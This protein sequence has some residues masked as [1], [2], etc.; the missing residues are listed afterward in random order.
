MVSIICSAPRIGLS[1]EG[2]V[3]RLVRESWSKKFVVMFKDGRRIRYV[4]TLEPRF[5]CDLPRLLNLFAKKIPGFL[6]EI[7]INPSRGIHRMMKRTT[8]RDDEVAEKFKEIPGP[9]LS[10]FPVF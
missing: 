6:I 10:K 9:V 5:L 3:R 7:V 8:E 4:E 2:F 1:R